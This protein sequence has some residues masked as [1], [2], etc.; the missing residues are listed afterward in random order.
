M[1]K[2]QDR[3]AVPRSATVLMK[4]NTCRWSTR[5]GL[6]SRIDC[7]WGTGSI[8]LFVNHCRRSVPLRKVRNPGE[9]RLLPVVGLCIPFQR[10][11]TVELQE[12]GI[13]MPLCQLPR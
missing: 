13:R 5:A 4:I 1:P 8:R 9:D 7:A 6:R 11:V 2:E 12:R 3:A 10:M